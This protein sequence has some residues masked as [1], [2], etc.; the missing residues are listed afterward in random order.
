MFDGYRRYKYNCIIILLIFY[1]ITIY[2]LDHVSS[3]NK[4]KICSFYCT[5]LLVRLC[6]RWYLHSLLL[7]FSF[8]QYWSK[9]LKGIISVFIYLLRLVLSTNMWSFLKKFLWPA[10][11]SIFLCLDELSVNRSIW[12]WRNLMLYYG[13]IFYFFV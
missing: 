9:R 1:V 6:G 7:V 12:F 3:S 13:A 4:I 2:I 10:E 5:Y 8:N 11:K